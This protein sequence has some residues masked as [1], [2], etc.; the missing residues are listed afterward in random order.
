M[1][2]EYAQETQNVRD[3]LLSWMI[4]VEEP[5]IV[6]LWRVGWPWIS[7]GEGIE[8]KG[9]AYIRK[10]LSDEELRRRTE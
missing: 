10:K 2:E 1:R 4:S 8:P 9:F 5:L 3:P 7:F 6:L